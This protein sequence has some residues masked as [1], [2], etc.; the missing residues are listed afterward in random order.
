MDVPL[1]RDLVFDYS[2]VSV[3]TLAS[4]HLSFF[5]NGTFYDMKN[6][7]SLVVLNQ[8]LPEWNSEGKRW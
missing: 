4:E 2:M 3:P 7:E 6:P 1:L 8:S 5:L